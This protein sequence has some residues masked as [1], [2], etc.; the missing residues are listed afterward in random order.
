MALVVADVVV[1]HVFDYL[2]SS[3]ILR[4]ATRTLGV[5]SVLAR[6]ARRHRSRFGSS[7]DFFA[8]GVAQLHTRPGRDLHTLSGFDLVRSRLALAGNLERFATAAALAELALAFLHPDPHDA[9]FDVLTESL[10][11]LSGACD[12]AAVDIGLLSAWRLIGAL[13]FAPSMAAC[14]VCARDVPFDGSVPFSHAEGGVVCARCRTAVSLS[15][16]L[17]PAARDAL[18]HWVDGTP[19]SLTTTGERRA[20]VRLLREFLQHHLAD[21]RDLRALAAWEAGRQRPA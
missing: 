3:R 13:G 5:Q 19:A 18:A 7:L 6:G 11:A 16:T 15:R 14:C 9:A 17:T 4:L 10:D 2:E 20:H 8:S 1:L 21:G 12:D